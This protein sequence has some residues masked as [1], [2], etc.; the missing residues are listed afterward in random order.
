MRP[1]HVENLLQ[2][3][4][5]SET[6]SGVAFHHTIEMTWSHL[7]SAVSDSHV[8]AMRNLLL[9]AMCV[10]GVVTGCRR[11][12]VDVPSKSSRGESATA[13]VTADTIRGTVRRIGNDPVSVLVL[14]TMGGAVHS[15][16]GSMLEPL[17]RANG[18]EVMVQGT[19]SDKLDYSASP[20][21]ALVF[22]VE[23]FFVRAADGQTATDGILS[24][25]DG[26]FFLV[27]P[28]GERKEVLFLPQELRGKVGSR[29]FLVGPLGKTPNGYGILSDRQ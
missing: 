19:R 11:S 12:T 26:K 17:G 22:E 24:E 6:L 29:V 25:R 9:A 1:P 13:A 21:G 16:R 10:P 5:E 28:S 15:L 27:S 23:Q 14:Q 7:P 3:P 20:R 8:R 2:L 4:C 18:L